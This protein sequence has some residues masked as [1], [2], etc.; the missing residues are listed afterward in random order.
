VGK[1]MIFKVLNENGSCYNGGTGGWNLPTQNTDGTWTPG[2]WMPQIKGIL[3]P[4][5][6]GYH[7]CEGDQVLAWL[8]PAVFE[9]EYQGERVDDIDKFVVAETR[10]L[11]RLN[12]DERAAR[13]FACD[14]AE[15]V[16]PLFEVETP[17]DMRPRQAIETA[18]RFANGQAKEKELIAAWA[19]ASAAARAAARAARD[20]AWA[21]ARASERDWQYGRLMEY[22]EGKR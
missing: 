17:E 19:T 14:C 1:E 8:G 18:R 12:W 11:R 5:V 15:R 2:E 7:L 3:K 9:A 20:V 13:L 4:C 21:A 16:L 22:L 6:N 10:L